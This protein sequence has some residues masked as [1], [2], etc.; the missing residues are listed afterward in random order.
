MRARREGAA[1]LGC[2]AQ[3]K[4]AAELNPLSGLLLRVLAL[5]RLKGRGV[6]GT[7]EALR[8]DQRRYKEA[9]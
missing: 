2:A 4:A 9:L 3:N 8:A 7:K 5:K 6:R 1:A